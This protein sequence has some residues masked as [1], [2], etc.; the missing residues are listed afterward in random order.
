M[1]WDNFARQPK[2]DVRFQMD[3]EDYFWVE[4]QEGKEENANHVIA[5]WVFCNDAG[6]QYSVLEDSQEEMR[7]E[8]SRQETNI[9]PIE[10]DHPPLLQTTH[11]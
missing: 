1:K 10:Y 4:K 9:Y 2:I 8:L 7:P 6:Q 3:I 11:L 5:S